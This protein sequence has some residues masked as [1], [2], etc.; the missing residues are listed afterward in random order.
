[1]VTF[2]NEVEIGLI[3]IIK[4]NK[5]NEIIEEEDIYDEH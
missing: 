3:K 1:M 5:N 2:D 4:K